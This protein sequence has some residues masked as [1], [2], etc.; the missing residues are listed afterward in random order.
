MKHICKIIVFT[1][2]VQF[3]AACSSS[4]ESDRGRTTANEPSYHEQANKVWAED[5]KPEEYITLQ[6]K[7]VE[8]MRQGKTT[9][10]S[11][12]ILSQMGY[13][14]CRNGEYL[15]GLCSLQ[16]A[17]DSMHTTP[18]DRLD[19]EAEVKLL[20]NTSNLYTRMGLYDE[21]FALNS[22]AIAICEKGDNSRIPD[23]Y[24]MRVVIY[25][26][27]HQIDS[28]MYCLQ[29]SYLA[30]NNVTD[31]EFAEIQRTYAENQRAWM[32]IEYPNYKP[33]SIA[34]AVKTLERN[35][36]QSQTNTFDPIMIGRGYVIM[37]EKAKGIA[38]IKKAMPAYVK[39]G[40]ENL[41]YALRM[42]SQSLVENEL[43]PQSLE[44]Y[45]EA[46]RMNDTI[47]ERK[48]ADALIGTDFKFR[49]T[50]LKNEKLLFENK[51][52]LTRE[53]IIWW[54]IFTFMAVSALIL[55]VITHMRRK[56][57]QI[58]ENRTAIERLINERINLNNEI[59]KLN[60]RLR[61]NMAV[62][63]NAESA[64]K[65]GDAADSS[66]DADNNDKSDPTNISDATE[67][68]EILTMA[69][70]T[71]EDELHF[72]KL[73]TS[74]QTGVIEKLRREYPEISPS[75]ELIFMLI[76]LHKS[77]DE[78][79]MTLGIKRDSV[80]KARYRLR[81][82]FKLDKETDLNDFILSM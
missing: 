4:H 34:S 8:E 51:L 29:Q 57:K 49:T 63:K 58:N 61:H 78:I 14:Y 31:T 2:M 53:R 21:A 66:G 46:K 65:Q 45:K 33:D 20:G 12:D 73:F 75:A 52:K 30:A 24:R 39:H 32:F 27:K 62:Y 68:S 26:K 77:N 10:P 15:K 81:S 69:V 44:I 42:L 3:F 47:N 59:E 79:S 55:S 23:L 54:S 48:K 17:M 67:T 25:E 37:G 38:M 60:D 9:I 5:G 28:A 7:A 74:L 56:N 6:E 18:P 64:R 72:R 35:L 41:E 43:S 70:L 1:G 40:T 19:T 82:L 71:K 22:E 13:F 76:R 36:S 11:V 16:E 50:Q 80:A